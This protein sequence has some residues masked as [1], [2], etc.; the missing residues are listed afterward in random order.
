MR[1][2]IVT[3]VGAAFLATPATVGADPTNVA[4]PATESAGCL[5]YA[6]ARAATR[7]ENDPNVVGFLVTTSV[8]LG[9]I[10]DLGPLHGGSQDCGDL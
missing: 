6:F 4:P 8:P 1:R 2:I 3:V 10:H 7:P 5:G 9:Y